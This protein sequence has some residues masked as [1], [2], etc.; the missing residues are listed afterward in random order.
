M[1]IISGLGDSYYKTVSDSTYYYLISSSG[2]LVINK[3][4]EQIQTSGNTVFNFT[5]I[6]T[7]DNE[8]LVYI[9]SSGSGIVALDKGFISLKD[10]NNKFFIKYN[11]PEI[12]DDIV[13]SIDGNTNGNLLLGTASGV[14]FIEENR[15]YSNLSNYPV[16][17]VHVLD[18]NKI[19]YSGNFG[20]IGKLE[21]ISSD[22]SDESF[23]LD[24]TSV[25]PITKLPIQ[26]IDVA[27]TDEYL[28]IGLA[29]A[30]GAEVINYR[31]NSN[32]DTSSVLFLYTGD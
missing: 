12:S 7:D 19:F 8:S 4:N 11:K 27:E 18:S 20:L 15:I 29:T 10:I 23:I 17:A 14:D 32:I 25:P 6:W 26:D 13:F 9:S 31:K 24:E 2:L 16:T 21:E 28:V 3:S 22:W 1:Q 30:S 5:D